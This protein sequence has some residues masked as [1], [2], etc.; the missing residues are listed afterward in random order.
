MDNLPFIKAGINLRTGQTGEG[1]QKEKQLDAKYWL[2][3]ILFTKL[4]CI[5]ETKIY[6][7]NEIVDWRVHML[8]R[9]SHPLA[10]V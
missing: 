4:Y 10:I 2:K 8:H 7:K 5:G 9:D 3:L 6:L 1:K